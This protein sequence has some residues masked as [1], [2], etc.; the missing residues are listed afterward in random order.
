MKKDLKIVVLTGVGIS[1]ESGIRAFNAADFL[2]Y[3]TA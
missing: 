3:L 1:A 2:P